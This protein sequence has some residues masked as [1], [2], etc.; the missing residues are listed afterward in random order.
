MKE[1]RTF[2]VDSNV[3][4]YIVERVLIIVE[5]IVEILMFYFLSF[6]SIFSEI[7]IVGFSLFS[8]L[9]LDGVGSVFILNIFSRC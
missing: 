9:F 6:G 5:Y 4:G 3:L 7:Y 8:F 1:L 2:W